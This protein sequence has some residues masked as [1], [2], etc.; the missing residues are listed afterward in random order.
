MTWDT[1]LKFYN[2]RDLILDVS[3]RGRVAAEIEIE[4]CLARIARSDGT[5][6]V[7]ESLS[8][9]GATYIEE[10]RAKAGIHYGRTFK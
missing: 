8:E 6:I 3:H 10:L 5:C 4:C 1:N 2:K 7:L 9:H